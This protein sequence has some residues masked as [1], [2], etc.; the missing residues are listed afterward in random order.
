[1]FEAD[2]SYKKP[3]YVVVCIRPKAIERIYLIRW[4]INK[5]VGLFRVYAYN[6]N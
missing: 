4:F 6:R 5:I 3:L 2:N 1:M